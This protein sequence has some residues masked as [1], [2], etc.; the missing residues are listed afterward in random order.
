[1]KPSIL[2][3][4]VGVAAAAV[5]IGACSGE[6]PE[7]QCVVARARI[8]GS[9]GS[10]ATTYTLKPGE[11]PDRACARLAAEP[12]G[13]QKFFNQDPGATDSVAVRSARLGKLVDDHALRPDP[14]PSHQTFSVGPFATEA[15]GPD[16]FCDVPTLT[17]ARLELPAVPVGLLDGGTLPDGGPPARVAQS[18]AYEWSNLRIYN[19]PGTPGTQFVADLRYTENGCTAEYVARG[20]WPVV[21]CR[22]SNGQPNEAACDPYADFDAGRLRG[23]GI[24]PVFPVKC[25]PVA[26]ICVLTGEV[27]SEEQP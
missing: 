24:N 12:V 9:T 14:D 27:P 26:L 21:T 4:S 17:P 3:L 6:E 5:A 13:L 19:T 1:M 16:N 7:P 2:G 25:D 11:N 8:D 10:F 18:Y 22:G 20:I 15:P 23:S